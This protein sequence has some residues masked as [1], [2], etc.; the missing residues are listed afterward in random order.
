MWVTYCYCLV[1][2]RFSM[3]AFLFLLFQLH[4]GYIKL[5]ILLSKKLRLV[6][7]QFVERTILTLESVSSY[8]VAA[9]ICFSPETAKEKGNKIVH[10]TTNYPFRG[11]LSTD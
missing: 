2:G 4:V 3:F 8:I 10:E 6:L 7:K 11:R 9:K 5:H 1:Y